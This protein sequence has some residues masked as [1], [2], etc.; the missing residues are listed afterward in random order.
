MNVQGFVDHSQMKPSVVLTG[1]A[2]EGSNAPPVGLVDIGTSEGAYLFRV[3]LPGVRKD[4]SGKLK[5]EIQRDGRVHIEGVIARTGILKDSS[6]VFQMKVQE[7][8]PSGPFTISFNLPGPVDP[9]LSS[10]TFRPDGILEVIVFKQRT[11]ATDGRFP[12]P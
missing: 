3:A 10:P 5:C 11:P 1:T 4:Q 2:K 6:T 7:L 9:R 8:C 12:P